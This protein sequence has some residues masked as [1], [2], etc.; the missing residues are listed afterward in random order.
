MQQRNTDNVMPISRSRRRLVLTWLRRERARRSWVSVRIAAARTRYVALACP[1]IQSDRTS[2]E[3]AVWT[4]QTVSSGFFPPP[5]LM[6]L[7]H[8]EMTDGRQ[9]QVAPQRPPGA[10]R[11]VARG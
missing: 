2:A 7:C 6:H 5:R 10:D 11:D 9:D 8:E 1:V 3:V 4:W